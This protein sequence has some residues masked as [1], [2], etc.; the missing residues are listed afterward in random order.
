MEGPRDKATGSRTAEMFREIRVTRGG[1]VSDFT[2]LECWQLA[3]KL[4]HEVYKIT[5]TFPKSEQFNL[6]KHLRE[7]AVSV[8][9]NIAEGY[10]R[11]HYQENLQF[12]RIARGSLSEIKDDLIA[13]LDEEYI[14]FTVFE[15]LLDLQEQAARSLNG[16]IR[17]TRR[18]MVD[19]G[20]G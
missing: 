7:A 18:W 5:R 9:S 8:T 16:Y 19:E 1:S 14:P 4:R 12:C 13:A 3:R 20:N 6:V 11:Y 2:D 15:A 10:G 17:S